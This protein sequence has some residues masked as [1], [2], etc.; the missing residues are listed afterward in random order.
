MEPGVYKTIMDLCS[1]FNWISQKSI[2][3]RR[4]LKFKAEITIILYELEMYLPLAF[5]DIMLHLMIHITPEILDLGPLFVHN[6]CPLERYNGVVTWYIHHRSH[7]EGSIIQAYAAEECIEFCMDYM[8]DKK[9]NR[10]ACFMPHTQ[11]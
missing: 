7:P 1:F 2:T 8:A 10:C 6:M 9:I 5:F 11:A 3:V 4:C